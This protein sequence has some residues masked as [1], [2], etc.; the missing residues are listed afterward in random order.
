[1]ELFFIYYTFSR[2]LHLSHFHAEP[3][4]LDP[5]GEPIAIFAVVLRGRKNY[6]RLK[7]TN[8]INSRPLL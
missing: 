3:S 7:A 5:H 1:M 8:W 2:I 4:D 6:T